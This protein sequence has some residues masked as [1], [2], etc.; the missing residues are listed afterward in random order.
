MS[1][2]KPWPSK[3][4]TPKGIPTKPRLHSPKH[5]LHHP[6]QP[7]HLRVPPLPHPHPR[8]FPGFAPRLS[9]ITA[10]DPPPTASPT[11]PSRQTPRPPKA[12]PHKGQT[13]ARPSPQ[14][15]GPGRSLPR[16]PHRSATATSSPAPIAP[17]PKAAY[18]PVPALSPPPD[19]SEEPGP[20]S[21]KPTPWCPSGKGGRAAP[22]EGRWASSSRESLSK[23][24]SRSEGS[25]CCTA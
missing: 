5:P 14:A 22:F 3:A 8:L 25:R 2:K 1:S 11:P 16:L 18:A 9:R 23:R 24:A 7:V 20:C 4:S 6:A 12:I 17:G 15:G 21:G 13:A 10:E 19:G